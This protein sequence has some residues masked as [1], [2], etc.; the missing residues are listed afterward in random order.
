MI[1]YSDKC[2]RC[3]HITPVIP[4]KYKHDWYL[5]ADA[6]KN[7][8]KFVSSD[9]VYIL[10]ESGFYIELV[11]ALKT[12]SHNAQSR[13]IKHLNKM[14]TNN[15]L[16]LT[17]FSKYVSIRPMI[18]TAYVGIFRYPSSQ[19]I[20][21]SEQKVSYFSMEVPETIAPNSIL[22]FSRSHYFPWLPCKSI[23]PV[24][25]IQV[26]NHFGLNITFYHF[27]TLHTPHCWNFRIQLW[28][29]SHISKLFYIARN[30]SDNKAHVFCGDLPPWSLYTDKHIAVLKIS[31][32]NAV[33]HLEYQ[34]IHKAYGV[35][36]T[37]YYKMGSNKLLP[38]TWKMKTLFIYHWLVRVHELTRVKLVVI[39][40]REFN[41]LYSA[42]DGPIATGQP[43]A[44]LSGRRKF[45]ITIICSTF[46]CYVLL[47]CK[48]S[49]WK[50]IGPQIDIMN[51]FLKYMPFPVQFVQK[52]E[53]NN[54]NTPLEVHLYSHDQSGQFFTGQELR[55]YVSVQKNHHISVEFPSNYS[56]GQYNGI[57]CIYG[58]LVLLEL[59]KGKPLIRQR[60]CGSQLTFLLTKYDLT[61]SS[62][63]LYVVFYH[64][65]EFGSLDINLNIHTSPCVG[66]FL[67]PSEPVQCSWPVICMEIM[68]EC[69]QEHLITISYPNETCI[70]IQYLYSKYTTTSRPTIIISNLH[71]NTQIGNRVTLVH[72]PLSGISTKHPYIRKAEHFEFNMRLNEDYIIGGN[73]T[74]AW[75]GLL[76]SFDRAQYFLMKVSHTLCIHPCAEI[77]P[78][79]GDYKFA[80]CD[81]CQNNYYL[82]IDRQE[83]LAEDHTFS[84][85]SFNKS[86]S[87]KLLVNVGITQ[88]QG[89]TLHK[90]ETDYINVNQSR[91]LYFG[92]MSIYNIKGVLG[93]W[94][95][96]YPDWANLLF[97]IGVKGLCFWFRERIVWSLSELC[98][99]SE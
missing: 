15:C 68:E 16:Y 86:C 54:T 77:H 61:M 91:Y 3:Q 49:L 85:I 71:G 95:H 97:Q 9:L 87:D 45:N 79:L 26:P 33:F 48:S 81:I 44:K 35:L 21:V 2:V 12:A 96:T 6:D 75:S 63:N 58:G 42:Y 46:Q 82:N 72:S 94:P 62:D 88:V 14:E 93:T 7:W 90:V 92:Y 67:D 25:L 8:F 69:L 99:M 59:I 1:N 17:G 89:R 47:E 43:L 4:V 41:C 24:L 60:M 66:I 27:H 32:A 84:V 98:R 29:L 70:H 36:E 53:L 52:Y 31:D 50:L 18:K 74:F 83:Y 80:Y 55:L 20:H 76:E 10:D 30:E 28:F 56:V 64:Y 73:V 57:D 37:H 13:Y 5:A 38:I 39:S 11:I 22:V 78:G 34:V 19:K 23:N 51:K 65:K 40:R